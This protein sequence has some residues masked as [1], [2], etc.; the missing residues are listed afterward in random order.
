MQRV[1][2]AAVRV[3]GNIAGAIGRGLVVWQFTL[4]LDRK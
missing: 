4:I 1:S 2:R 3:D